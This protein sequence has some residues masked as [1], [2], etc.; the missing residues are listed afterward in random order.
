[1]VQLFYIMVHYEHIVNSKLYFFPTRCQIIFHYVYLSFVPC[2]RFRHFV[3]MALLPLYNK[4]LYI[5]IR[6]GYPILP[7]VWINTLNLFPF[8][9]LAFLLSRMQQQRNRSPQMKPDNNSIPRHRDSRSG[10]SRSIALP[11]TFHERGRRNSTAHRDRRPLPGAS[12][13]YPWPRNGYTSL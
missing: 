7:Q 2:M 12:C 10:S 3:W 9:I 13:R 11:C 4:Y 1:M 6:L 5:Y 8:P